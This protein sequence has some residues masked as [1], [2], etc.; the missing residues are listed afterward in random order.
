VKPASSSCA[1]LLQSLRILGNHRDNIPLKLYTTKETKEKLQKGYSLAENIVD[2]LKE[3]KMPEENV[4]KTCR[5][6]VVINKKDIPQKF[7]AR[8]KIN[9]AF[10]VCEGDE[11]IPGLFRKILPENLAQCERL[12][13][14]EVIESLEEKTNTWISRAEI[15]HAI[16]DSNDV[17]RARM[18]DMCKKE[19]RYRYTNDESISGLLFKKENNLWYVRLNN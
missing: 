6:E 10:Q 9:E 12:V 2:Q 1:T 19:G 14:D 15:V 4:D 8:G 5:E 11:D 13:Y 7:L 18:K 17:L 16:D 3:S